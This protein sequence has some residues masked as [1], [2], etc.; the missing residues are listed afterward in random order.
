VVLHAERPV[1]AKEAVPVERVRLGTETVSSE[2][3]VSEESR[4]G[5]VGAVSAVG[6]T[7]E[8]FAPTPASLLMAW[9]TRWEAVEVTALPQDLAIGR[10][11]GG[12]PRPR[13]QS[14]RAAPSRIWRTPL[15]FPRPSSD[16][17]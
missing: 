11:C 2:H 15:W 7:P 9:G 5:A 4:V 6:A 1:V 16:G 8:Q 10:R 3:E 13:P 14:R 12:W 17:R